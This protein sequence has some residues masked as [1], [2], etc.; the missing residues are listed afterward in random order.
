VI[1]D[2]WYSFQTVQPSLRYQRYDQ[3]YERGLLI[4]NLVSFMKPA[5]STHCVGS[6]F[7]CMKHLL[8]TESWRVMCSFTT[9][10]MDPWEMYPSQLISWRKLKIIQLL[11]RIH[12]T[13][14]G[15]DFWST[16][17]RSLVLVCSPSLR[18][19]INFG[20]CPGLQS[21]QS[22]PGDKNDSDTKS[23]SRSNFMSGFSFYIS[24]PQQLLLRARAKPLLLQ[25][26]LFYLYSHGKG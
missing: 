2:T 12:S 10:T 1:C 6:L 8:Y 11:L 21:P 22:P 3:N 13:T 5:S 9:R 15:R 17:V 14:L 7:Y 23:G 4:F 24:L 25:Q 19:K 18:T 16:E 26:L 20:N